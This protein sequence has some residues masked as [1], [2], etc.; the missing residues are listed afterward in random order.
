MNIF[1]IL[2]ATPWVLKFHRDILF[3]EMT[4]LLALLS[5]QKKTLL[6][7]ISWKMAWRARVDK[8]K[9]KLFLSSLFCVS[10]VFLF[11]GRI[12]FNGAHSFI[13]WSWESVSLF[14][15][16]PQQTHSSESQTSQTD[17]KLNMLVTWVSHTALFHDGLKVVI[18]CKIYKRKHSKEHCQRHNRPKALSTLTPSPPLVQSRSFKKEV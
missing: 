8:I 13:A 15:Y 12:A 18:L 16:S 5:L 14:W 9:K 11:H 4:T 17:T 10:F 1:W 7:K 3:H 6:W 2:T